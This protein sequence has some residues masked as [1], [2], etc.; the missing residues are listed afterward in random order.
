MATLT[1]DRPAP[2]RF[3][4]RPARDIRPKAPGTMF[5]PVAEVRET[6][7]ALVIR[8]RLP[9]GD[10]ELSVPK[11]ALCEPGPINTHHSPG[12]PDATPC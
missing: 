8:I 3:S 12:N 11:A 10:L 1:A 7:T 6:P 9:K 4:T 5:A 2:T